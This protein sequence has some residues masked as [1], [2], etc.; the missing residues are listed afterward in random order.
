M[1]RGRTG[2]VVGRWVVAEAAVQVAIIGRV[3]NLGG[4]ICGCALCG[5]SSWKQRWH[6]SLRRPIAVRG[7][8]EAWSTLTA[9]E[10][11]GERKTERR[12]RTRGGKA[13]AR[14]PQMSSQVTEEEDE[15]E[16]E[17]E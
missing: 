16:E 17:E 6:W 10:R 7:W 4:G 11:R 1:E 9:A 3:S 8:R 13:D 15:E 2:S 5:A 12:V 14:R